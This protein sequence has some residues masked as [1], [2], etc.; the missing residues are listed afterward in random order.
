M[1]S[2]DNGTSFLTVDFAETQKTM[3]KTEEN[4]EKGLTRGEKSGIL[5]KHSKRALNK[6]PIRPKAGKVSR[7][8]MRKNPKKLL[9]NPLTNGKKSDIIIERPKRGSKK[10]PLLGKS[11]S[12]IKG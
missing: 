7:K 5:C 2:I 3:Q 10:I 1:V 11:G 12:R 9:G 6:N 4:Y 8:R